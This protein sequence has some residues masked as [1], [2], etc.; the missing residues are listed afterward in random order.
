MIGSWRTGEWPRGARNVRVTATWGYVEADGT[1]PE[2]VRDVVARLT[3]QRLALAGD[4]AAAEAATARG[5]VQESTEGRSYQLANHAVSS[6][7]TGD[8]ALDIAL[9]QLRAP[10]RAVISRPRPNRTR[11]RRAW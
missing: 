6:G 5:I 8:R 11:R 1:T 3:V 10:V 4:A 9:N 2:L 7:L